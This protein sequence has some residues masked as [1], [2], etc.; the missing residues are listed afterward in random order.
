M[1]QAHSAALATAWA[2]KARQMHC[3]VYA[4]WDGINW[5]DE[6]AYALEAAIQASL[7]G[8][9]GLPVL[10]DA[11]AGQATLLM[12]NRDNRYSP[13]NAASPIHAHIADG[14]Y[15]VPVR[16]DLSY[17]TAPPE[18]PLRQFTGY[19]E[20]PAEWEGPGQRR[21][22][23][24]CLDASQPAQQHKISSVL[25]E[26]QRPDELLAT[27]LAAAGVSPTSLDYG[28]SVIPYAWFDDENVWPQA[29]AI[30][31]ADGGWLYAGKDGTARYERAT[32]WLEGTDHTT[33]QATLD[34]SNAF[35]LDDNLSWRDCYTKV[36]VEYAPR[37]LG[38]VDDVYLATDVIEVPP[39]ASKTEVCRLRYPIQSL[40]TP[41][42][43]TDYYAVSAGMV[44]MSASLTVTIA[45][46]T[47]YAQRVSAQFDNAHASQSLYVVDF[48]LRGVPAL[49]DESQE[50]E[51]A[52]VLGMIPGSKEWPLRGNPFVQTREQ[53]SLLASFLRDR[54][55]RPRRLWGWRGPACPWLELGDRVTLTSAP[56]GIAAVDCYVL[57]IAQQY[58]AGAMWDMQLELLPVA[59]L[60]PH[61]SYFKLGTSEWAA[62]SDRIFY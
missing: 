59:N 18:E 25:Y 61:T 9:G 39:G 50:A 21:V 1:A 46:G 35:R 33:S 52:S 36:I 16:V 11:P 22:Q 41:V 34:R 56:A 47:R 19:I 54:L 55:E 42:A 23:F 48:K 6:T 49:G 4:Q 8:R 13:D 15:R 51:E 14:I 58:H 28:M 2:A 24:Q 27:L 62:V 30:A 12:D 32:H 5:A 37:Y 10:G 17:V 57:S 45:G 26:R 20:A 43:G 3:H 40:V 31:A 38:D 60:Y 53:A 7:Y 29:Q 44:D